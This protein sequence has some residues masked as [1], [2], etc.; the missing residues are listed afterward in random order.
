MPTKTH[1]V[2]EVTTSA[3]VDIK[4]LLSSSSKDLQGHSSLLEETF[5]YDDVDIKIL[6]FHTEASGAQAIAR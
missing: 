2:V 3:Y 4:S 6:E 5:V 1:P